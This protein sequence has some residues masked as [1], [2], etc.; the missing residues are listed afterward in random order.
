M[1][2]KRK[3]KGIKTKGWGQY[4]PEQS[5]RAAHLRKPPGDVYWST[6]P[7]KSTVR[8]DMPPGWTFVERICNGPNGT[9]RKY[10]VYLG[11]H[12]EP[13]PSLPQA[14][15]PFSCTLCPSQLNTGAPSSSLMV[16][17]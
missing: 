6:A 2:A 16:R 7:R 17:W 11:P 5:A 9:A 10:K 14:M 8:L 15:T 3:T 12:G 1:A 4:S 13:A